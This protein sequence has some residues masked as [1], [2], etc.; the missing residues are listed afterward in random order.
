[1]PITLL[2]VQMDRTTKAA[3]TCQGFR[4]QKNPLK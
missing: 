1:M 4:K 3:I 2:S